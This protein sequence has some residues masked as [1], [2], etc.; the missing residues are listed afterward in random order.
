[1][2][3]RQDALAAHREALGFVDGRRKLVL[4]RFS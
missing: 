1:M 3:T 4:A 2:A